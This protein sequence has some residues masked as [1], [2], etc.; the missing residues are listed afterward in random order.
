MAATEY[1]DQY[2]AKLSRHERQQE[3][4]RQ[5]GR[6]GRR[7]A[8]REYLLGGA[9][10]E[11]PGSG[12]GG[13]VGRGGALPVNFTKQDAKKAAK[14]AEKEERR[15][16]RRGEMAAAASAAAAAGGTRPD[17]AVPT[18]LRPSDLHYHFAA[19]ERHTSG[20]GSKLMMAM[21]WS[22]GQGLGRASQGI[23]Q[24]LQAVQ[25]PKNRGLGC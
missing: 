21:G 9:V 23:A 17:L 4:L 24:P 22:E 7:Q 3:A 12:R 10:G 15:A 16:Q 25:R 1:L 2:A 19:F 8:V 14:K 6:R 18:E 11:A 20:I 13:Y 5:Q